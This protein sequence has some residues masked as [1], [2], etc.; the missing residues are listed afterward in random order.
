MFKTKHGETNHG[1]TGQGKSEQGLDTGFSRLNQA[2]HLGGWPKGGLTEILPDRMGGAEL[3][4]L[5]PCLAQLSRQPGLLML[6]APPYIP[7]APAWAQQGVNLSRVVVVRP[8]N[9]ADLLWCTEQALS[10]GG[11][12][13]ISWLNHP[14]ISY[15]DLR[16]LQ[17]AGHNAAGLSALVRPVRCA[18]Q[19]SPTRL[20]LRLST[21]LSHLE[22]EILKQQGGWA[23]QRINLPLSQQLIRQQVSAGQ[24]PVHNPRDRTLRSRSQVDSGS[25]SDSLPLVSLLDLNTFTESSPLHPEN[26]KSW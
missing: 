3:M 10:A 12:S 14:R 2:L 11:N 18:T 24:L 23:G 4:L 20:R 5:L 13:V 21:R 19:N 16:K 26:P 7:Y 25:L 8:P 6:I 17:I 1:K 15:R 9:I 22:L